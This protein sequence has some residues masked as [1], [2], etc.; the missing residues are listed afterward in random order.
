MIEKVMGFVV[1]T[2]N[3]GDSSLILNI[4]TKEHGLIGVMGK[5][6]KQMKSPLRSSAQK[7]TYGY[8]YIYYKKEKLS[9]LKDIDVI[10]SF[11][12]LHEDITLIGYL[13]YVAELVT[14]V[15]KESESTLLFDLMMSIIFKMNEGLDPFV[16]VNILEIKCLPFLGVGIVLD[17]CIKC[18]R[19]TDIVTIDGD[20]GGLICKNCYRKEKIVSLKTI[21]LLRMYYYIDIASIT[22]LEIHAQQKEEI[23]EFLTVYYHRY[24]GMYL[25]SKEF[26]KKIQ[27]L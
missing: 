5:G 21:Q 11:R 9:L 15:Y 14:Q 2:V 4:L 1:S 10:D 3:F 13:N 6:V 7:F 23:D 8:F 12:H 22:K 20:V 26:L 18:G 27:D 19:T 25:K 24:T 16:L 17:A